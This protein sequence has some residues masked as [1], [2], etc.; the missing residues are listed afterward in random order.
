MTTRYTRAHVVNAGDGKHQHPT[1]ALLDLY[2]IREALGRTDGVSVAIVGDVLHS[3]VARSD[4]QAFRLMGM[5]VTVIGPPPL[6]PL[7]VEAL[8]VRVSHDI[9]DLRAHDVAYVLRMQRERMDE[10]ANYVPSLREY[11]ERWGVTADR[12]APHQLVMHPGP[13]NRGVEIA[14]DVAD[15]ARSLI[16]RQ[17]ESGL[18]VRMAV[19]HD[20]IHPPHDGDGAGGG[21]RPHGGPRLM[22]GTLHRSAL[23]RGHAADPGRPRA[24][25]GR[26]A[27]RPRRRARRRRHDR[28]DRR[29]PRRAAARRGDRRRRPRAP[30]GLRRPPRAPARAGPGAQGGSRHGHARGRRR[31]LLRDRDDGEHRPRRRRRR[32]PLVDRRARTGGGRHPR[33]LRRR[34]LDRPRGR[35][36]DRDVRA[37]RRGRDG[38]L[39]RRPADRPR[40]A[41]CAARSSTRARSACRSCST[42][43]TPRSRAAGTC[44]RARSRPSSG[45]AA[46]RRSPSRR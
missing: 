41:S 24:R 3:R 28:R 30:A 26:R 10:G 20:L 21:A 13:M 32:D 4:I 6:L 2:T 40:R 11:T 45:S 15:S 39:G 46:G 38:V 33:R 23:P 22:P 36:P 14:S 1:Q 27:R 7:E 43:R 25:P 16:E 19:L 8:G 44:A 17:V 34:R 9:R 31:R 37:R 35:P 18:V 5:D 12:L 42:R 29:A